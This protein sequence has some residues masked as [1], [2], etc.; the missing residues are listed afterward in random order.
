MATPDN[1]LAAV[2]YASSSVSA[3]VGKG[4]EVN[5]KSISN[6]P[7]EDEIRVKISTSKSDSYPLYFR[8]PNWC[9]DASISINGEAQEVKAESGKYLRINRSWNDGDEINLV[10]PKKLKVR[11]WENNHNSLSVDYGPLTFSL[12]IGEKYIRKESDE[13]AIGDS[14]WQKDADTQNWPSFEIHPTTPWNYGLVLDPNNLIA[15]FSMEMKPWPKDNYPFTVD[16]APMILKAK[17][18][19]IPAWKIDEYGLAGELKDSPVQSNEAVEIIELI[20]MGA[21]RLRI[22]AFPVIG[23]GSEASDW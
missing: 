11:T 2:I 10:L 16:A 19:R 23:E 6:Y 9:T 18:K 22:S 21:A 12:K 15:S 5:I 17:G 7:F 14:K 8:I 13:T 4:T 1:G 20:P 3:K